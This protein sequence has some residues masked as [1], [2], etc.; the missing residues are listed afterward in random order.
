MVY[1]RGGGIQYT[2]SIKETGENTMPRKSNAASENGT[3]TNVVRPA[4]PYMV[5]WLPLGDNQEV[6]T[7]KFSAA[8]S[9][10]P[11][12]VNM[13]KTGAQNV[14]I[15]EHNGNEWVYDTDRTK[16]AIKRLGGGNGHTLNALTQ[17][18]EYTLALIKQSKGTAGVQEGTQQEWIEHFY[19]TCKTMG[20]L[21]STL[22]I[23]IEGVYAQ[24]LLQGA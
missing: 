19:H 18:N 23:A 22:Q 17:F 7:L 14:S 4:M 11:F 5:Q 21:P 20:V 9:V 13:L 1:Y 24:E 10:V 3:G 16:A 12:A 2:P 8:G 15:F 6:Q